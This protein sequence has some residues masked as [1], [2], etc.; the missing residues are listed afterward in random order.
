MLP[1]QLG[2]GL[3]VEGILHAEALNFLGSTGGDK[4]SRIIN[5]TQL[6]SA[7]EYNLGLSLQSVLY[8]YSHLVRLNG[9]V[10]MRLTRSLRT[11]A[12]ESFIL[13]RYCLYQASARTVG[14]HRV[15][16]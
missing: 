1:K 9:D 5:N 16:V 15:L 4:D 3:Q 8:T 11:R 6:V 2:I 10:A 13:C 14:Y 12:I 7:Y